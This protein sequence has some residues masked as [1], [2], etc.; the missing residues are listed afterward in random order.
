MRQ[1]FFRKSWFIMQISFYLMSET[2]R[3]F[4]YTRHPMNNIRNPCMYGLTGFHMLIWA[5]LLFEEIIAER[6]VPLGTDLW[7]KC[8]TVLAVDDFFFMR[9]GTIYERLSRVGRTIFSFFQ[10]GSFILQKMLSHFLQNLLAILA[11]NILITT[12][13]LKEKYKKSMVA[14]NLLMPSSDVINIITLWH[15]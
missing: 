10:Y 4:S 2:D 11:I 13:H 6:C 5:L 1:P 7:K 3:K 8:F 15:C 14:V 9:V 12:M